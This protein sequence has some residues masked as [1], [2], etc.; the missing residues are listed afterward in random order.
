MKNLLYGVVILAFVTCT[1][2]KS[3]YP[4]VVIETNY[5][6]IT[7]ELYNDKAPKTVAAFLANVKAG[8]YK[9]G[10]FYRALQEESQD[11]AYRQG[12]VQGGINQT[13]NEKLA[14]LPFIEHEAPSATGLSHTNGVL[15][16]ART[17]PGS[18][19]TEFF[20]CLGDQTQF[21]NS[22]RTQPDGLGYAAFGRVIDGMDV[23]RNIHAA[24]TD[25]ETIVDK[26]E[27]KDIVLQ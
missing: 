9:D 15:S 13:H 5:G 27:I 8:V 6:K 18:A 17:T 10:S 20:I 25:G 1:G 2:K 23:V 22:R 19:K 16:M 4:T 24:K 7:A 26:V 3:K 21:D 11:P 12:V 14:S